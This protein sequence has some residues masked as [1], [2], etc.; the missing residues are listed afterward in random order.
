MSSIEESE[1]RIARALTRIA[2]ALEAPA[3]RPPAADH[4]QATLAGLDKR[5]AELAGAVATLNAQIDGWRADARAEADAL[6]AARDGDRAELD[7][8]IAELRPLAG[9]DGD[10]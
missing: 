3:H 9:E 1:A 4:M 10:A 7:A 5:M 2:A 8:V 6:R